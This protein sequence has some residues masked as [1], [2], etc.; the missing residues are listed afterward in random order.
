MSGNV[1]PFTL[2]PEVILT[3]HADQDEDNTWYLALPGIIGAETVL[4]LHSS[5]RYWCTEFP[6][7]AQVPELNLLPY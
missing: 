6:D 5:E 1:L 2:Q 4:L 7:L 3:D